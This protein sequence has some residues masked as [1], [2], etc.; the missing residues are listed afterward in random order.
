MTTLSTNH[1]IP[2]SF[3]PAFQNSLFWIKKFKTVQL[4]SFLQYYYEKLRRLLLSNSAGVGVRFLFLR[5]KCP[6]RLN[7][8]KVRALLLLPFSTF[9]DVKFPC[10]IT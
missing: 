10:V 6:Y 3:G 1:P 2:L 8:T 7:M 9:Q 5:G 4:K